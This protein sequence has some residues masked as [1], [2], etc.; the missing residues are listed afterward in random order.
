MHGSG[1]G[2]HPRAC[3]IQSRPESLEAEITFVK[4]FAFLLRR[5]ASDAAG[6]AQENAFCS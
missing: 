5:C 1:L 4:H 6:G 3:E 2:S